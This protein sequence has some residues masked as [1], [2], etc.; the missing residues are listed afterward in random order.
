LGS[1]NHK[2]FSRRRFQMIYR[3]LT[4]FFVPMLLDPLSIVFASGAQ[5][6]RE[7]TY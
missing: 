4:Q 6:G 7:K 2:T 1:I 5:R 3:A